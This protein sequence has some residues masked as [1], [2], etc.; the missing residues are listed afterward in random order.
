MLAT[1]P[2]IDEYTTKNSVKIVGY[3]TSL[4]KFELEVTCILK[5]AKTS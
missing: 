4:P 2:V 5:S 1:L 3:I